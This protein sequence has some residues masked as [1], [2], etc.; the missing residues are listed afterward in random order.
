[1]PPRRAEQWHAR[2]RGRPSRAATGGAG[3]SRIDGDR[4]VSP[5]CSGVA[6]VRRDGFPT[7]RVAVPG[8]KM[9]Q[10]RHAAADRVSLTAQFVSR[11]RV[12]VDGERAYRLRLATAADDSLDVFVTEAFVGRVLGLRTGDRYRFEGLRRTEPTDEGGDG[13]SDPADDRP[14]AVTAS[15][16]A[17]DHGTR[18]T[19]WD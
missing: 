2:G 19:A 8:P 5:A 13:A 7:P 14:A 9:T 18:I 17:V 12:T 16:F 10:T 6:E 11:C 15:R 1:M 3:G 4:P